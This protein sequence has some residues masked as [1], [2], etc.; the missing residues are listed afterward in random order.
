MKLSQFENIINDKNKNHVFISII[1]GK[2][3]NDIDNKDEINIINEGIID[4]DNIVKQYFSGYIH[5][6]IESNIDIHFIYHLYIP[7]TKYVYKNNKTTIS[8]EVYEDEIINKIYKEEYIEFDEC[9]NK[10]Y[11]DVPPPNFNKNDLIEVN[12][13]ELFRIIHNKYDSIL[14]ENIYKHI[15]FILNSDYQYII[16][17]ECTSDD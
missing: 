8:Y 1:T 3:I 9:D 4:D 12:S 10:V 13:D 11:Y 5:V 6:F 7:V 17:N 2:D 15:D 16:T 14:I